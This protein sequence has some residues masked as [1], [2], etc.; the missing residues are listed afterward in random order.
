MSGWVAQE[1]EHMQ[2]GAIS[3]NREQNWELKYGI[4]QNFAF[5]LDQSIGQLV[6]AAVATSGDSC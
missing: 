4:E 5:Y 2:A 3:R 1:K 6:A